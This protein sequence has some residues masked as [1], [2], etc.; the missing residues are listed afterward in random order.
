MKKL[1]SFMLMFAVVFALLG[2]PLTASAANT[3]SK[4]GTVSITSG[5]LNVRK[6]ASTKAEVIYSLKKGA[7]ITLISKSGDWWKVEY[8]GDKYGF[9]HSD[10]IKEVSSTPK[11]VKLTSGTLNVR[12]GAGTSYSRIAGLANGKTV[13]ELSSSNGW[14]KILFNGTKI[15]YVS[16]RYLTDNK[17]AS[18][19]KITLKV[20]SFKQYDSRWAKTKIG[21]SGK[22]IEQIGCATT[23]IA[24]IE[25]FRKGTTI[26]PDA[27]SKKLSYTSS[28]SVYWPSDYTVVTTSTNYLSK[29]YNELKNGRAVLLG[30]KNKAGGQ[31][32]VVITGYNG[33]NSLS[34][35]TFTVNDPGSSTRTT[36]KAFLSAYPNFYKYFCYSN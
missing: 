6:S 16:S 34:T 23:A 1:L 7:H 14:S 33:S 28:G 10:Y 19:P 25:S 12:S 11:N 9:C 13:I 5:Y 32:W 35:E 2:L 26:Y 30:A 36:L 18:Y 20:P 4:A 15:G 3:S 27:M 8:S 21:S 29:I 22:T 17:A 24:M 31:H